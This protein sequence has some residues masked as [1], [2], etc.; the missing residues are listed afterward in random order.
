M[1]VSHNQRG[2]MLPLTM[3]FSLMSLVLVLHAILLLDS[4]R[5]FFHSAYTDFQLRQLRENALSE[6]DQSVRGKTLPEHGSFVYDTGTAAF[7]TSET[8]SK[9]EVKFTV[10][11]GTDSETDKIVY[12]LNG[13]DIIGWQERI[14]P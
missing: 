10:S 14:D 7:T 13:K 9:L 12:D 3:I 2:F 8:E 11:F 6:I 5:S 1:K 4:D